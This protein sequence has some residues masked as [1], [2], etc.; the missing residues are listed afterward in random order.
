MHQGIGY[1]RPVSKRK[2]DLGLNVLHIWNTSG[3]ASVLS[4][5][6]KTVGHD[7]KVVMRSKYDP[8]CISSYYNEI[9]MHNIQKFYF[10]SIWMSRRADIVH[11]HD[12]LKQMPYW[13]RLYQKKPLILHYHG[14]RTRNTPFEVR[15]PRE[16]HADALLLATPDLLDY[17]Y[18][19]TPTYLPNPVDTDLFAPRHNIPHNNRGLVLMKKDQTEQE[20]LSLLREHGFGDI[21]WECRE[22]GSTRVHQ[23]IRNASYADMPDRLSQ[24][25]WYGDINILNS[26]LS[27]LHSLTG[28]QAMSLGVKTVDSNFDVHDVL[29]TQHRPENVIKKLDSIYA[30][31]LEDK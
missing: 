22:R 14:S 2:L 21:D 20:T 18:S 23:G 31:L 3:V 24:Y 8:F 5:Q 17:K 12:R 16:R 25:E 27:H 4:K 19:L 13:R 28:L 26:K 11:M 15:A 6:Q 10:K 7:S 1:Y 9:M 30:A 29:P